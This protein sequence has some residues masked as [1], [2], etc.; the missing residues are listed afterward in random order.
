MDWR[1]FIAPLRDIESC[2]RIVLRAPRTL[3]SN[4]QV[5]CTEKQVAILTSSHMSAVVLAIKPANPVDY[6]CKYF[7][8]LD[9]IRYRLSN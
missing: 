6:F 5:Y 9:K 8:A 7:A 3:G 2:S 4:I 1:T